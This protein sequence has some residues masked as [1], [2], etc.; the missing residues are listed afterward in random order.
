MT[1]DNRGR[2]T[3]GALGANLENV[4]IKRRIDIASIDPFVKSHSVEENSNS[5][6][7]EVAQVLVDLAVKHN[8]AIDAPHHTSKGLTKPGN[9]D[10]G[11]GASAMKD[12]GRLVYTLARMTQEEAKAFNVSEED[13]QLLVRMDSGKVNITP[14]LRAAR[15]FRLIGVRLGNA[16]ELYP[17]GDEVQAIETWKPPDTW[18][19]LSDQLRERILADIED[20]L[21]DGNRYT[22]APNAADRAAWRVVIKHAPNK[23]EVQ[24][25]DIIK[26]WITDK[27]LTS[28]E[29]T[30]PKTERRPQ[31]CGEGT[32]SCRFESRPASANGGRLCGD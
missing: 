16:T 22:D 25:R 20:G 29:Y 5:A 27:V 13:R 14:P 30:N 23:S 24:A 12:A 28:R 6:I 26:K 8:I 3:R 4:I 9:A 7:D 11:R 19:D 10:S 21:P 17:H 18:A 32:R 15:W 1:A 31:A 2:I